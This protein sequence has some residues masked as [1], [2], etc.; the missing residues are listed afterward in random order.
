MNSN[1]QKVDKALRFESWVEGDF[2][3]SIFVYM[4]LLRIASEV[5]LPPAGQA[6]VVS[7]EVTVNAPSPLEKMT[8]ER[9]AQVAGLSSIVKKLYFD[10]KWITS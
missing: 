10:F 3:L 6:A 9:R 1:W 7:N 4:I 2:I 8:L 5:K